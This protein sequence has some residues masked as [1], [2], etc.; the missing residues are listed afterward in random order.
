MN[1]V[2]I[3]VEDGGALDRV[4]TNNLLIDLKLFFLM[5]LIWEPITKGLKLYYS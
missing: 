1:S 3:T 4:L 2:R 5:S